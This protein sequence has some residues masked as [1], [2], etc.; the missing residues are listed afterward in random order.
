ML[1]LRRT[2]F[3]AGSE[4]ERS[5]MKRH[6]K[7]AL[8]LVSALIAPMAAV[9]QSPTAQPKNI[10]PAVLEVNGEKIF[11]AEIS[12][13][14]Q[15]I[16]AQLGGREN[17]QDEEALV[18]MATQRAVEQ[19]LLAQE[20]RRNNIQPNELRLAEMVQAIEQQSGG[21]EALES[22]RRWSPTWRPSA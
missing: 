16:A 9:A 2:G 5:T 12:M 20:A 6:I 17:V 18:Q 11:A 19:T 10:N 8:I 1:R 7:L 13:I 21:R 14:M 15:N 3:E 4:M 22:A